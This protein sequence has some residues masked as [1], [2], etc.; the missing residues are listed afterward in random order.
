MKSQ[1]KKIYLKKQNL[2]SVHEN[3]SHLQ[4]GTGTNTTA[5]DISEDQ[6]DT[7]K[8]DIMKTYGRW[9]LKPQEFNRLINNMKGKSHHKSDLNNSNI[10]N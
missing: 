8:K 7:N 3:N 5:V 2:Q 10:L 9:Y 1:I 6:F 4:T